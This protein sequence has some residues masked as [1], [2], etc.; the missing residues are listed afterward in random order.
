[1]ASEHTLKRFDEELERLNATINEMGGLT[2]SQFARAL[3]AV[4]DRNTD[5]AEQ[6]IAEDARNRVL[7]VPGI[8]QA[9]VDIVWDPPWTQAMISEDGK[10]QLGLI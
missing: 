7:T 9:R 8:N 6:V 4:R 2:E 5:A 3:E 1:M 10:M